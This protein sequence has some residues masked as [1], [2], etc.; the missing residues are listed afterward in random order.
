MIKCIHWLM[1]PS[2]VLCIFSWVA[3][4]SFCVRMHSNT[5]YTPR[6]YSQVPAVDLGAVQLESYSGTCE[7]E[8]NNKHCG[9]SGKHRSNKTL[10]IIN[11]PPGQQ[12]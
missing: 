2:R 3:L 1:F 7:R 12:P 9:F 11:L 4:Q 5:E 6:A 10:Q 8:W